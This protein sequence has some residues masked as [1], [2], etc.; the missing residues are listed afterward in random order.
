MDFASGRSCFGDGAELR[1]VYKAIRR[2]EIRVIESV[3]EFG[4]KLKLDEFGEIECA[5]EG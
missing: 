2:A 4:T 3:E 5:R 1:C